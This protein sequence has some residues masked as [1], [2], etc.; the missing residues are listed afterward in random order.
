MTIMYDSLSGMPVYVHPGRERDYLAQGYLSSP[1]NADVPKVSVGTGMGAS[2]GRILVN[3]V[4]LKDLADKLGLST[5]Q[6]KD[7][8]ENRPY[9]GVED[10]IAKIPD[11]AWASFTNLSYE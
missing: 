8:R 5:Q 1:R 7:V 6:A 11:V 9:A 4:S 3:S 10:L 2:E